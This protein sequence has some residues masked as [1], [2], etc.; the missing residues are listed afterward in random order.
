MYSLIDFLSNQE[1]EDIVKSSVSYSECLRKIGY[2]SHSGSTLKRFKEKV[3]ELNIST[4]HFQNYIRPIPSKKEDVFIENASCSQ[5]TL[6]KNFLKEDIPYVC[7]ICGQEPVWNNKKLTLIL[8]HIN[9]KNKDNR[10]NNLRWVCPNCNQ[11][12]ETTGSRNQEKNYNK[13]IDCGKKILKSSI[14]CRS[15]EENHRKE[16]FKVENI[17]SRIELKQLLRNSSFTDIGKKYGVS[18]TTVKRWCVS[19]NLPNKMIDIKAYSDEEW[20][21]I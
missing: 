9:G 20:E 19:Y 3:N 16:N 15:C 4:S 8:D 6:R 17:V 11:Q 2:N 21:K 7:S 18:R 5:K 1:L 14:R 13:C 12:L 10:L